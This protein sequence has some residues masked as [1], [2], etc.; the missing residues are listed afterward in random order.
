MRYSTAFSAAILAGSALAAPSYGGYGSQH[1]HV[2]NV[3]VVVE[4]VVKTVY[5]TEGYEIPKPTSSSVSAAY[6]APAKNTMP[7]YAPVK[8]TSTA[9]YAPPPP[10]APTSEAPKPTTTMVYQPAPQKPTTYDAPPPPAPTS[11]A[12]KPT[13]TPAAPAPSSGGYM[14]IVEEARAKLGMKSLE[15]DTKLEANAMNV[16][17]EGN[18]VMKHKLNPGTY[19]QVL[20]PGKPDM[21]SFDHVFYGGWL[22]E[23]PSLPGLQ[24]VCGSASKGWNYE[25][26]TG[27]AEILTSDQYTKIGCANH[28]GIWCCDLA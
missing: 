4:T 1:K 26:Q 2:K 9:V 11:E 27:H 16:V 21:E 8:P 28:E 12:P 7:A 19:G 13:T 6:E 22:C 5:V 17:V 14:G 24:D 23:I 20:A 3:H 25:G 15:C 18:G 10:P